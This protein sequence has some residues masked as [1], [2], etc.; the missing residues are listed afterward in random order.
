M[1]YST[2]EI[3]QYTGDLVELYLFQLGPISF[4]YTNTTDEITYSG[5]LYTPYNLSRNQINQGD[6]VN[7][8]DL[9]ITTDRGFL[10]SDRFRV[11]PPSTPM[12]LTVYRLHRGDADAG[13]AWQGRVISVE[14]SGSSSKLSCQ[15]IFSS[16]KRI[17]IRRTYQSTCPHVLYGLDCRVDKVGYKST[18][19]PIAVT[20]NTIQ[21][22]V[23]A[24]NGNNYYDGGYVEYIT[25]EGLVEQRTILSQVSDTATLSA[26]LIGLDTTMNFDVYTGCNRTLSVCDATFSNVVNYGGFPYVPSDTPF[27]GHTIY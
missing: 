5:K 17:G 26:S 8:G 19:S 7:R 18:G 1:T 4:T 10:P 3:G 11:T 13:V 23:L 14:W 20:S 25:P 24:Q 27:G 21:A 9:T 15:S 2:N 22:T 16:I 12:L 6:D